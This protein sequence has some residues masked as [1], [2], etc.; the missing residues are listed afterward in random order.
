MPIIILGPGN[1]AVNKM[2]KVSALKFIFL[3]EMDHQQEN[4][5]I[6]L[7]SYRYSEI[8]QSRRRQWWRE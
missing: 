7:G 2:G 8:K 5:Y 1:K 3:R 6:I 4:K